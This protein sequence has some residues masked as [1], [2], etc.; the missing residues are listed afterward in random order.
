MALIDCPECGKQVSDSAPSC[1]HCGYLITKGEAEPAYVFPKKENKISALG[2]A[3]I[4]LVVLLLILALRNCGGSS[5]DSNKTT[6]S[7]KSPTKEWYEGGTLHKAKIA[8]WKKA[9]YRNKL[10]TCADFM[11]NVNNK[12]QM[13]ELKVRAKNLVACIDEATEGLKSTDNMSVAEVSASCTILLEY[14]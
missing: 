4:I 5:D 3:G 10:A 11:A 9:T 6:Y 1:P 7:Q 8:D 2:W 14:D 13:S 12:I